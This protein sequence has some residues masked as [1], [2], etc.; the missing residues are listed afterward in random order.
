[1]SGLH[2]GRQVSWARDMEFVYLIENIEAY[3]MRDQSI[4][5]SDIHTP[6]GRFLA[7]LQ[8]AKGLRCGPSST[9]ASRLRECAVC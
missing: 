2:R 3:T 9:G 7:I 4:V 8:V 5:P 1:M 6:F